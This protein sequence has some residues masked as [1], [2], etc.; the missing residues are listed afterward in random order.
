[1][2]KIIGCDIDGVV[3]DTNYLWYT[4]LLSRYQLMEEY[5][6][7]PLRFPYNVSEMFC[8]PDNVDPFVFWKDPYL[9]EGLTPIP[10]SVNVLQQLYE[11]GNKIRFVSAGK[12]F[13][14]KSK[15]Y[16]IEKWFPFKE[17]VVLT[18][19]KWTVGMDIMIDD[20]YHVLDSVPEN[21][22]TIKFREDTIQ[23]EA[24]RKHLLAMNWQEVYNICTNKEVI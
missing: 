17:A 6:G 20:T 7:F 12:G 5:G 8:I 15:Y 19:E 1:M 9:Y 16:F 14:T 23:P 2:S 18:K 4:Y 21:V 13:H 22:L 24:K 10:D 3:C 11:E